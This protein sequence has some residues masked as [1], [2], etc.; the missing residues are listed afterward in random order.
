[1][2]GR[3]SGG[4]PGGL[5]SWPAAGLPYSHEGVAVRSTRIM[6]GMHARKS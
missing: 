3:R 2:G 1:M 6:E 4:I 5:A